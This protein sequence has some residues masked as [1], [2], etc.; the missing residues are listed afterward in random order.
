MT[1]R[2]FLECIAQRFCLPRDIFAMA[3]QRTNGKARGAT[4]R[5]TKPASEVQ[6]QE[7]QTPEVQA[8]EVETPEMQLPAAQVKDA[9]PSPQFDTAQELAAAVANKCDL[10]EVASALLGGKEEP[11]GASVKARMWETVVEYLYGKPASAPA[12]ETQP[13]RIVWDLPAPDRERGDF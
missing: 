5:E 9:Q 6:A 11:K 8:P 10:V 1:T 4:K 3:K 7:T 12:A 2:S 13:L